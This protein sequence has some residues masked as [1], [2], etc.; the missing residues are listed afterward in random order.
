M[1]QKRAKAG[2]KIPPAP[3]FKLQV[4]LCLICQLMLHQL[5]MVNRSMGR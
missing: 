3:G 1:Q 5:P 2:K 4:T